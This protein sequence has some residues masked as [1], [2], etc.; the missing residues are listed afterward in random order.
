MGVVG[1]FVSQ[2]SSPPPETLWWEH[3]HD[4]QIPITNSSIFQ[5]FVRFDLLPP[6]SVTTATAW[7]PSSH[8][9]F[10]FYLE[11]T[12]YFA[13]KQNWATEWAVLTPRT[14]NTDDIYDLTAGA[15]MTENKPPSSA[16]RCLIAICS[17]LHLVVIWWGIKYDVTVWFTTHTKQKN[18]KEKLTHKHTQPEKLP[19]AAWGAK[20]DYLMRF[21]ALVL[22]MSQCYGK[23]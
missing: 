1:G 17:E 15:I 7:R 21:C 9:P 10:C 23:T 19:L 13:I 5:L 14:I 12:T 16:L 8:L 18:K 4:V 2:L 20:S 3:V 22:W 6:P 11:T